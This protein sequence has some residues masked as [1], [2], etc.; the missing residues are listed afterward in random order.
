MNRSP[1]VPAR[2]SAAL[3]AVLLMA[4]LLV[5]TTPG[6][7]VS[8]SR[9]FDA[10]IESHVEITVAKDRTVQVRSTY[11]SHVTSMAQAEGSSPEQYREYNC[12][13]QADLDSLRNDTYAS[14]PGTELEIVDG[15]YCG[16]T[17][18]TP[19]VPIQSLTGSDNLYALTPAG[20]AHV[21]G[22]MLRG[23]DSAFLDL[24]S[25]ARWETD[26]DTA[27]G[28][29]RETTLTVTFPGPVTSAPGAE[30]KGRTATWDLMDSTSEPSA[31]GSLVPPFPW[32]LVLLPLALLALAAVAVLLWNRA[33]RRRARSAA[34]APVFAPEPSAF[35][36]SATDA[37]PPAAPHMHPGSGPLRQPAPQPLPPPPGAGPVP[38][39]RAAA[40]PPPPGT[41]PAPPS[42]PSAAPAP[43]PPPPR[44]SPSPPPPPPPPS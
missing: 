4:A 38:P 34:G 27:D 10:D 3:L 2:A 24:Y 25:P 8:G 12:L 26:Y 36:P 32:L 21:E 13:A 22:V 44:P 33:R 9:T 35:A 29:V 14:Y 43:P 39:P 28:I 16:L 17:A 6:N 18:L 42:S 7:A 20:S 31:T 1:H 41:T 19:P 40:P 37:A 5:P 30:I 11:A 15:E 23:E